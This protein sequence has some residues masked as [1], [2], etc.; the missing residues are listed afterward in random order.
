MNEGELERIMIAN[1]RNVFREMLLAA[2]KSD[3]TVT[4]DYLTQP[5]K[6]QREIEKDISVTAQKMAE[7]LVSKMKGEG[8]LTKEPSNAKLRSMIRAT[9]KESGVEEQ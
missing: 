3:P 7:S 9:L 2:F 8:L 6:R 1:Y 4:P 5:I